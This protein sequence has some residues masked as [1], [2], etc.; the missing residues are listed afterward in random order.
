MGRLHNPGP[1]EILD[2]LTILALKRSA[3]GD[4]AHFRDEWSELWLRLPGGILQ[5]QHL[6]PVL[7]LAA[8]NGLLWQAE[9]ALRTLRSRGLEMCTEAGV[10]GFR[11][12]DLN[13]RRA[14]LIREINVAA[15]WDNGPEK[16]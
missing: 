2:R 3:H 12:Q 16:L 9:D 13:D 5:V 4:P 8:V 14:A 10:V 11:I 1:G 6:P 7:L 15:G